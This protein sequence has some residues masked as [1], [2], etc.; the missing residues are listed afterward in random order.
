MALATTL[1]A[2]PGQAQTTILS[3]QPARN[4]IAAGRTVPV[5]IVFSQ[6]IAPGTAAGLRV[7]GSALRGLRPGT[8]AGGG[9]NTLTFNPAQSFAP[10][11]SVSVSVPASL[12]STGG[13]AV[14]RQVYQFT[15]ATGGPGQGFFLDTA[16]VGNTTSRDQ[17]LADMDNDGD[18]DLITTGGLY[19]CRVFAND[20]AGHFSF[21]SGVVAAQEP[22]GVALADVNQDG[23]LDALVADFAGATVAVCLNDGHGG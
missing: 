17:L 9:S 21:L 4:A 8:L 11:E 5:S 7:Y 23:F 6:A 22:A 2:G 14:T 18:L 12:T 1:L 19:G 10:G 15:A 13:A 20:G 16:V 3:R